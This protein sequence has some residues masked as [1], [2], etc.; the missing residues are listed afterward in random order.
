MS[1][2]CVLICRLDDEQQP[3]QLT[4]L[5]RIELPSPDAAQLTPEHALDQL[6]ADASAVGQAVIRSLVEQQWEEIDAQAT[7]AHERLFPPGAG[8][9]RGVRAPQGRQ[10]GGDPPPAPADLLSP[11]GGPPLPSQ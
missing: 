7:A 1:R 9:P 11:G 10:P 6:E 5:H 4:E 8:A 2:W 3:E